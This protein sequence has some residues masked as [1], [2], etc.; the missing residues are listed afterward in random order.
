MKHFSFYDISLYQIELFLELAKDCNFSRSAERLHITQ[1]TL[2]KR[3]VQLEEIVGL[4]L[5]DRNTRPI[6]LPAVGRRLRDE[7]LGAVGVLEVSIERER[8]LLLSPHEP[9]IAIGLLSSG[10]R[11]EWIDESMRALED[12]IPELRYTWV[13]LEL[14]D[15]KNALR[16]AAADLVITLNRAGDFLEDWVCSVPLFACQRYACMC[17]DNPL[18]SRKSLDM[19]DLKELRFVSNSP[20]SVQ[21]RT[22]SVV[23]S[24]TEHG[25]YPRFSRLVDDPSQMIGAVMHN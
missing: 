7:W 17:V 3:I 25:F 11:M 4:P 16:S 18:A 21:A 2:S 14:R 1:P 10:K 9:Q 20:K 15:W 24:C 8:T 23:K 5:F 22:D 13:Y 19:E 6:S 12:E